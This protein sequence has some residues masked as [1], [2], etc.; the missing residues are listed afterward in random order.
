MAYYATALI[1]WIGVL[2]ACCIVGLPETGFEQKRCYPVHSTEYTIIASWFQPEVS[3]NIYRQQP[4]TIVVHST[5][6]NDLKYWKSK[7]ERGQSRLRSKHYCIKTLCGTYFHFDFHIRGS[8][9]QLSYHH[10]FMML[11]HR[12]AYGSAGRACLPP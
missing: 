12:M 1:D 9:Y 3:N 2:R 10:K 6:Y 5:E 4:G 8:H 11:L 7:A